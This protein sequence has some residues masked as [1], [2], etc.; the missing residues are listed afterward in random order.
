MNK[1]VKKTDPKIAKPK[2]RMLDSVSLAEVETMLGS[3]P[4]RRDM[5]VAGPARGPPCP[6]FESFGNM[7]SPG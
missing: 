7:L 6:A 4:R 2:G 5:V 3:M 1:Q